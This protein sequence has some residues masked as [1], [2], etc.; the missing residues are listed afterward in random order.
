MR[1][2]DSGLVLQQT[3]GSDDLLEQVLAH[4]GIHSRERVVEEVDIPVVVHRPRQAD[5]LLLP[6]REVDSLLSDLG[7][8]TVRKNLEIGPQG[9]SVQNS[10]VHLLVVFPAKSDIVLKSGVLHPR[11][12]WN[13]GNASTDVGSRSQTDLLQVVGESGQEGGLP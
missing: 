8:V 6:A 3:S 11:L 7:A 10:A 4:V 5:P 1:D 13:V 2:K 9:A 12:L